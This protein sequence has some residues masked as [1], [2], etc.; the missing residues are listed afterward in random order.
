[1]VRVQEL[2]D[3]AHD[4]HLAGL[5]HAGQATSEFADDFFLVATQHV[6]VDFRRGK[7]DAV[8]GQVFHLVDHCRVM[9]QCFGRDA[10]YVQAHAAQGGVALYQHHFQAQV[11]RA[12]GSGVAARAGAQHQY[13]AL[14]VGSATMAGSN[15][16][17]HG[18]GSRGGGRRS[19][20]R[21][22]RW[23]RVGRSS[24]TGGFDHDNNVAFGDLATHGGTHFF[25]HTGLFG[26]DFHGG[27]VGFQ[28]DQAVVFGNGVAY[29]HEHF[30]HV[31]IAVAADVRHFQFNQIAHGFP[32]AMAGRLAAANLRQ[33]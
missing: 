25:H 24:G 21:G 5:G 33:A 12:E 4:L 8:G 11:G 2:A 9:Q 14:D 22:G 26:R 30:D 27:F 18:C 32:S 17:R 20:S 19:S 31:H 23:C 16:G 3:T 15:R 29:F 7:L 28:R 13:V 6:D 10:A 1:M